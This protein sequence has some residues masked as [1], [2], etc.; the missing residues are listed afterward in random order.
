ML[1][2]FFDR[3]TTEPVAV[4][5]LVASAVVAV[6]RVFDP[7]FSQADGVT[8]IIAIVLPFL[9]SLLARSKVSPVVPTVAAK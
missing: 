2:S 1:G 3:L 6:I 4:A 7:S 9:A 5:G 8:S